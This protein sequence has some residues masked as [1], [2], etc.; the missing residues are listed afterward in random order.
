MKLDFDLYFVTSRTIIWK[1]N[2]DAASEDYPQSSESIW[3]KF[4]QLNTSQNTL[5]SLIFNW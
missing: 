2:T 1:T 4:G 3:Q 5:S